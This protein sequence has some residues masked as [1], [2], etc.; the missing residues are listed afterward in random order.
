MLFAGTSGVIV[1]AAV[2]LGLPADYWV[3]LIGAVALAALVF[4]LV[5]WK[6]PGCGA[7]LATRHSQTSCPGCD[8]PLE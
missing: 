3:P 8:A 7:R 5:N 6:C 2:L 1:T 4:S